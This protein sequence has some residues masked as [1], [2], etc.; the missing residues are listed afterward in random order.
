[1][2]ATHAML[3]IADASETMIRL[4][5]TNP[6]LRLGD[7]ARLTNAQRADYAKTITGGRFIAGL[8]SAFVVSGCE[9]KRD[10]TSVSLTSHH[11]TI[12]L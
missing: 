5:M 1:M 9:P 11:P 12:Q 7:Q 6:F 2:V 3:T 8:A 4:D 10:A